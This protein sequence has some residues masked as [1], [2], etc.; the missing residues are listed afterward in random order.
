M[1]DWLTVILAGGKGQRM[2]SSVSKVLHKI[3]GKEIIRHV[4]DN[5]AY[6]HAGCVV[7]VV[8]PDDL[9]QIK[10]IL[11]KEYVYVVQDLP[12]GTAHALLQSKEKF[13]KDTK[14]IVV[15]FGDN[16][17]DDE[18]TINSVMQAHI[19]NESKITVLTKIL[20]HPDGYGRI[21]RNDV[22]SIIAVTEQKSL[23][24]EEHSIKEVNG[25]VYCFNTDWLINNIH[26]IAKSEITKEYYLTGLISLAYEQG[27]F[28]ANHM[29]K[30]S[31]DIMG[32]NNKQELAKA[33]KIIQLRILNNHMIN[34]VTI[35]DPSTTYIDSDVI[36][37]KDS[38]V[39]PNTHING[40]CVV[41]ERTTLG[42]N[43]VMREVEIGNDCKIVNSFIEESIL[44]NKV[45]IGPFSHIRP[46]CILNDNVYIGNY[47]ETKNSHIGENTKI[48]HFGYIGDSQVGKNVNIGAGTITCNYDGEQKHITIINDGAFIGSDT[49]LVAPINI[50]K[51]V[52]TG[53]GSVI[54]SDVPDNSKVIGAPAR[55]VNNR[56]ET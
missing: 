46:G 21:I 52:V 51:N 42:P 24:T 20:E 34:G 2:K 26:K 32:I 28:V 47:V 49:M 5:V 14:N 7:V 25:G 29:D 3:C 12:L 19:S 23:S 33:E 17:V 40:G 54:T 16:A 53:A 15:V 39:L 48:G 37:G 44:N 38:V 27:H 4:S 35:K 43:S 45:S 31:I 22:G 6:L 1:N 41:G 13:P 36:L 30:S 11:N 50:G 18:N 10:P 55:I 8:S 9:S 56:S